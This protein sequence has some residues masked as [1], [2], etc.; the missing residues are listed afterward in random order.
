MLSYRWRICLPVVE[1]LVVLTVTLA[2]VGC[3]TAM[4]PESPKQAA[5]IRVA[6]RVITRE[7]TTSPPQPVKPQGIVKELFPHA[8]EKAKTAECF[9]SLTPETSMYTVVQKCGRPDEERGSGLYVFVYH[10]QDGSSVLISTPYLTR[11]GYVTYTDRSG[12]SSSLLRRK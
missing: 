11:I 7:R 5:D 8:P 2:L 12:N 9:R 4:V 10:L 3:Q 6:D 1:R